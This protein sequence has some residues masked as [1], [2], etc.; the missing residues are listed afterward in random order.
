MVT[1]GMPKKGRPPQALI[2]KPVSR[3]SILGF[4]QSNPSNFFKFKDIA[5]AFNVAPDDRATMRQLIRELTEQGLLEQGQRRSFRYASTQNGFSGTVKRHPK[6]FGWFAPDATCPSDT[7]EAFI[8]PHLMRGLVTGDLVSIEMEK[9]TKGF[10]VTE[11]VPSKRR[12][13]PVVAQLFLDHNTLFVEPEAHIFDS[14]IPVSG[15][16]RDWEKHVGD[17]VEIK[18]NNTFGRHA[19][20]GKLVRHVGKAG[21][22]DAEIEKVLIE[23]GIE[24]EFPEPVLE[25]TSHYPAEPAE[26]DYAHRVDLRET[27]LITIDGI[28]AKDFDD[29]VYAEKNEHGY[30]VLVAIADVSHY[31]KTGSAL[32]DEAQARATSLYYPGRVVPMLPEALSNGL[33]SLNP[34]VNRLCMVAEMHFN[35]AGDLV[36]SRFYDA[37]MKSHAR[38]TY[39]QVHHYFSEIDKQP[40][41]AEA[42]EAIPNAT[43]VAQCS[44]VVKESLHH[45][46]AIARILRAKRTKRGAIDFDL[47]E[48][49]FELNDYR[50]PTAVHPL[51]RHEPHKMIEDLMIA[52]NEAVAEHFEKKNWP[53]MYRIHEQP[54]DEKVDKAMNLVKTLVDG[55]TLKAL[56]RQYPGREPAF[57]QGILNAVPDD[58]Q[59]KTGIQSL[60]LRAMMQAKYDD[61]N[62]GHYGL[63]SVAYAHFTSPIRRYPDLEVHRRLRRSFKRSNDKHS[64]TEEGDISSLATHCSDRERKTTDVERAIKSLYG[65]WFMQNH[66]GQNFKG[67]IASLT[68]FGAFV[69]LE[70]GIEGL[71]AIEEFGHGP[72]Q[73]DQDMLVLRAGNRIVAR[74]GDAVDVRILSTDV[75]KRQIDLTLQSQAGQSRGGRSFYESEESGETGPDAFFKRRRMHSQEQS[76]HKRTKRSSSKGQQRK[77]GPAKKKKGGHKKPRRR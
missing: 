1:Q 21:E 70:N 64:V 52:A 68:N 12:Q 13:S 20:S 3:E 77:N 65:V 57:I 59:L 76:N 43:R 28:T 49:I 40:L 2:P 60:I 5:S 55:P 9:D 62:V 8:P 26:Q 67:T 31:V 23:F 69:R 17:L 58:A 10:C 25:E 22:L 44:D 29:A 61:N 7:P 32:D 63:A 48:T 16:I 35:Q 47:P 36:N 74:L 18:L 41:S 75:S 42:A 38:L 37:V 11:L 45:L 30:R 72:I 54:N 19:P 50:Q 6:G 15:A 27:P 34:G 51:Q 24:K 73:Y 4:F 56:V 33:C 39:M 14:A 71:V 66:L 46:R 53:C